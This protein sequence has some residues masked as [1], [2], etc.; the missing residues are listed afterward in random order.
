MADAGQTIAEP[1][2]GSRR[3]ATDIEL[4]Q[5]LEAARR[6]TLLLTEDLSEPAW[7][8]PRLAIVN[9]PLWELA[10]VGWF[11]EHWCLRYR[12]GGALGPSAV[13][14]ADCLYN[15]A[16]AAHDTRWELPLLP[17]H[18]VTDWLARTLDRVRERLEREPDNARLLYFCEL[19]ACHEEMHAEAFSYTRQ[20]LEY[21]APR[22][23]APVT[24]TIGALTGDA[25]L[26]G[27]DYLLGAAPG[28]A[29]VFDNEKWLHRRQ[30][31]PFSIARAAVTQGEYAA[32]A[33]DDG[34]CERKYWSDEGWRWRESVDARA[35]VYWRKQDGEWF[36][37]RHDAWLPLDR[38][39]AII[40]VNWFE[41]QAYCRWAGRRLPTEAEWEQAAATSPEDPAGAGGK[42]YYP[43][44]DDPPDAARALLYGSADRVGAVGGAASGD[45]AWGC[46]QLLGN[47]WEWT[48]D[49]FEPYPG[50]LRDPYKEYSEPWFGNHKVLRGGCFATSAALI[51]NTW[52]NFYTP[53]RRDVYAGFR[54]CAVA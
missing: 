31:A 1:I 40:H 24:Q 22:I 18:A 25:A 32:F 2:A 10:H 53:D 35:P 39:A 41:A 37:R 7:L 29:F 15:S 36:M 27:G 9:P 4:A 11:Q 43:W 13:E 21:P 26:P 30:L 5:R 23:A 49:W 6:R 3:A 19:A 44:G 8:G 47:V 14:N 45:S 50:Y 12:D 20:T 16:I 38:D 48:A 54:T 33:D 51:R 52:R 28:A 46:R 17:R 34:Y 42:R